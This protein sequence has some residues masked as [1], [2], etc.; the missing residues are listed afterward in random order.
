MQIPSVTTNLQLW[1]SVAMRFCL[2]HGGVSIPTDVFHT[3]K[4]YGTV[5]GNKAIDSTTMDP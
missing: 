1:Y 4:D 2:D 3:R 5:H